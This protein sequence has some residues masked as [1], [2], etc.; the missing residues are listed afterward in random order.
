MLTVSCMCWSSSQNSEY[1]C[2][3]LSS[4]STSQSVLHPLNIHAAL[5]T[6][7]ETRR[8]RNRLGQ[9]GGES[10]F[11]WAAL[12]HCD[13]RYLRYDLTWSLDLGTPFL[14]SQHYP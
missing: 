6:Q 13:S 14:C 8:R 12:L 5:N 10:S 2:I 7:A 1:V 9:V 4:S 3:W 11:P